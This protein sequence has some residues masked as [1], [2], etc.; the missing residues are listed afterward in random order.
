MDTVLAYID[1]G[2]GS[3]I[4]QAL[5]AALVAAPFVFRQQVGRVV[6]ASL[7]RR[8]HRARVHRLLNESLLS[9]LNLTTGM[10]FDVGP[11]VDE[12]QAWTLILADGRQ[13]KLNHQQADAVE[14][15]I[16]LLASQRVD[17]Q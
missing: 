12:G 16:I 10:E 11:R 8:G 15:E 6:R 2:S 3:L 7:L 5:I 14:V 4:I 13:V 9:E 1:A 17:R